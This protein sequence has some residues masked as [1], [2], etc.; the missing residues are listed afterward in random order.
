LLW[1]I[2]QNRLVFISQSLVFYICLSQNI[3]VSNNTIL[4]LLS[5]I[6]HGNIQKKKNEKRNLLNLT[7]INFFTQHIEPETAIF[8]TNFFGA[9]SS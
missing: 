9:M 4:Y 2:D 3:A 8:A 1:H 7:R 5:P 6:K